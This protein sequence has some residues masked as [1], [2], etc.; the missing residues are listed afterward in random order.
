MFEYY[1]YI[2]IIIVKKH[3]KTGVEIKL[4]YKL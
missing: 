3:T 4:K 2:I 1:Y